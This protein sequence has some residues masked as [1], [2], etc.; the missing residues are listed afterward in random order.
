MSYTNPI[1]CENAWLSFEDILRLL[2]KNGYLGTY[3][4][5]GGVVNMFS[6]IDIT[7]LKVWIDANADITLS[8]IDVTQWNNLAMANHFTQATPD[9]CPHFITNQI[10]GLPVVDGDASNDIMSLTSNVA[11]AG[12]FALFIILGGV[13]SPA[14]MCGYSSTMYCRYLQTSTI[15]R[16][17]TSHTFDHSNVALT[18]GYFLH[19]L[20]RLSGNARSYRNNTESITGAIANAIAYNFQNIFS[21]ASSYGG[22]SIAELLLYEATIMPQNIIDLNNYFSNKYG[23]VI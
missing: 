12:D 6:P 2:Y 5:V 17:S 3:G 4:D 19:S 1:T 14:Y 23:I 18:T 8:G 20:I 13:T 22:G 15:W 7:G 16:N 9:L 21:H 10:N 11:I